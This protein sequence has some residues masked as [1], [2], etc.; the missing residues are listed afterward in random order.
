MILISKLLSNAL[1]V[2]FRIA[3]YLAKTIDKDES[4]GT[5]RSEEMFKRLFF[6]NNKENQDLLDVGRICSIFISFNIELNK[7]DYNNEL[8]I[9]GRIIGKSPVELIRYANELN[10]RQ[11]VQKRG[12]M[13]AVLPH[14]ISNRLADEL[15]STFPEEVVINEI[16]KFKE[17]RA[18]FFLED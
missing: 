1:T 12:N 13:R 6:Q 15:L 5:L 18:I 17:I 7:D 9:L 8:N 11:I 10:K 16:K 14:A 3:R 2:I 4:I